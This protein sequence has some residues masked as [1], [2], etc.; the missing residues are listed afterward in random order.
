MEG[1]EGLKYLTQRHAT[2]RAA[3]MAAQ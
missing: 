1:R 3:M 2:A